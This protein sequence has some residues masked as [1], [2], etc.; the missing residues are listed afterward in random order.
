M[1]ITIQIL[2]Y[3]DWRAGTA[4]TWNIHRAAEYLESFITPLIE[5]TRSDLS[6]SMTTLSESLCCE[7][8]SIEQSRDFKLPKDLYY[9]IKLK[10]WK[11]KNHNNDDDHGVGDLIAITYFKPKCINDLDW[12]RRPYLIALVQEVDELDIMLS[13]VSSKPILVE[14]NMEN[15]RNSEALFAVK[16]INMTT[17]IRIWSALNS[18]PKIGNMNIIQQVLQPPFAVRYSCPCLLL[19]LHIVW[20]CNIYLWNNTCFNCYS[21]S[22]K[23]TQTF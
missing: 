16:L 8:E 7:I 9:N 14:D 4:D 10:K 5:E 22:I 6:S 19:C 11:K 21:L 23:W 13:V 3:V 12:P 15:N 1:N 2:N 18:D 17:N 20:F